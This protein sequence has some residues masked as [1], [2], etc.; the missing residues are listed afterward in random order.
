MFKSFLRGQKADG[1]WRLKILF[2]PI[3]GPT[4]LIDKIFGLKLYI[5]EFEEASIPQ[6]ISFTEFDKYLL[7]NTSDLV[8][9]KKILKSFQN[10]Y[11]P[12]DYNY[13]LNGFE[14]GF[15]EF[16]KNIIIKIEQEIEF[17]SIN[18][19]IQYIDNSVPQN[20]VYNVR[21]IFLHRQNLT[22]SYFVFFDTAFPLKLIGKTYRNEKMYVD[23]NPETETKELIFLNSNMDY[24]KNFNFD[25]FEK[26]IIKVKYKEIEIKPST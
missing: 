21:G 14:I 22:K 10:E 25:K 9:I 20:T 8:H 7:I 4:W 5:K 24:F 12:K 19:L 6:K 16:D 18:A 11:D 1:N 26:E 2:F 15:S 3:W 13:N 23:L 17:A